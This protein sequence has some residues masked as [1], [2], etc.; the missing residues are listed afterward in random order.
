MINGSDSLTCQ[1]MIF[2]YEIDSLHAFGNVDFKFQKSGAN[3]FDVNN[4]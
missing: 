1:N 4:L 2:W 3:V